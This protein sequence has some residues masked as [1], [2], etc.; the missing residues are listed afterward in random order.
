MV[1]AINKS[2]A[3]PLPA[4]LST[5]RSCHTTRDYIDLSLDCADQVLR[6]PRTLLGWVRLDGWVPQLG[7]AAP[8]QK[9]RHA[10]LTM[11]DQVNNLEAT[12][13]D[14]DRQL[15]NF[16]QIEAHL[17]EEATSCQQRGDRT[18]LKRL[19]EEVRTCRERQQL[20]ESRR[21]KV[22]AWQ[23]ELWREAHE[24][25]DVEQ[26]N[27]ALQTLEQVNASAEARKTRAARLDAAMTRAQLAREARTVASPEEEAPQDF[28]DFC[29]SLGT[30]R[31]E[32]AVA[33]PNLRNRTE[34]QLA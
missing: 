12:L 5:Y 18:Q 11:M 20:E 15:L 34:Q 1:T 16:Q 17:L 21:Q 13:A 6:V 22:R 14:C 32:P 23:Q 10:R 25:Q 4:L 9:L 28:A 3:A 27:L 24:L 31:P 26:E 29:A 30:T 8:E 19:W 7:R 2:L 33:A